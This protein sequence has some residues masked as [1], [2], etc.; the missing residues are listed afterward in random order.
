M[1]ELGAMHQERAHDRQKPDLYSSVAVRLAQRTMKDYSTS[2]SAASTL[3]P[4]EIAADIASVYGLVRIADEIV[5]GAAGSAGLNAELVMRELDLLQEQTTEALS[6]GYSSNLIVHAFARCAQK[7]GFEREW[8]LAFFDS[9][10]MDLQGPPSD[11]D[12]SVY[13]YGSAEVIGLMCTRVFYQGQATAVQKEQADHGAHAL[14][15][16]FQLINFLRDARSDFHELGRDYL[17]MTRP[18]AH[19]RKQ[20]IEAESLALLAVAKA[21]IPVLPRGTRRA[22]LAATLLYEELTHRLRRVSV[23]ELMSGSRIRVPNAVKLR[24]IATALLDR[25]RTTAAAKGR[26]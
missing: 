20:E 25:R 3:L 10:R 7:N 8:I 23:E 19:F 18:D 12:L 9:M 11:Q 17:G 1:R 26:G 15:R 16:A 6:S 13:I 22:V 14:G 5:D 24:I 21:N 4:K 2:F